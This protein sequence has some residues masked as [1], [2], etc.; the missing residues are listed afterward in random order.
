MNKFF[1]VDTNVIISASLLPESIQKRAIR[2]AVLL[3]E[4]AFSHTTSNEFMDV[5][6]RKKFDKYFITE[7]ERLEILE[8]FD[9]SLI[10]FS[11]T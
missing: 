6:F 4:I 2:K 9:N 10:E 5:I 7:E 8:E 11:P 1:V 3:G